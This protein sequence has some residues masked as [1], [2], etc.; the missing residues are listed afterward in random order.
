[1]GGARIPV[2]VER[3]DRVLA[4]LTA[5]QLGILASAAVVAWLVGAAVRMVLPAPAAI[6]VAWPVLLVGLALALG[7]RDGLPLDRLVLVAWRHRRRA[8][9]MVP[10]P[11]GVQP[12]PAFLAGADMD[13]DLPAPL[14][15]PV[16]AL[17]QEGVLDLGAEGAAV[18]SRASGLVF[19][20]R[21]EA[22]QDALVHGFA[23][24]LHGITAPMQILVRAVPVDL[25]AMIAAIDQ[26]AGGLP[27]PALEAA[28][29]EHTGF[30][31]SLAARRDVMGREILVA[32][33]QPT[34]GP[35]AAE[36]L[37]RR[38]EQAA[39][40]LAAAGVTLRRLDGDQA[41]AALAQSMRPGERPVPAGE[42][43]MPGEVVTGAAR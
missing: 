35:A 43:S 39:S 34:A 41:M 2:D 42:L 10:A 7:R 6:A 36:V 31:S 16:V 23:R 32:F 15:L 37:G 19:S 3:A 29:R 24:L 1:M 40:L 12:A 18:L 21:T 5:R 38:A 33:R 30:L 8:R 17:S 9:L 4:G 26:A 11:E 27:H 13:G 22:E 20:L 28:A 25:A 14:E